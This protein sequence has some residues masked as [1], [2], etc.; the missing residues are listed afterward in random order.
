M[1]RTHFQLLPISASEADR[2]RTLGGQLY[3]SDEF[4]GYPCRQCLQDAEIGQQLLLVS[5]DPF[6]V[7]S[8]YR[9]AGPIF[10]HVNSCSPTVSINQ[11][12]PIQLT[13]RQLSVRCFDSQAM[14]ID[15][16]LIQ[17]TELEATLNGFFDSETTSYVDVHNAVRGC[18]A[19][20]VERAVPIS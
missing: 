16:A 18:W 14:M 20:R 13:C 4:P 3:V 7:D 19:V 8:P 12:F 6:R 10:L 9:S 17:G 11:M 1:N 2:L 15:A 5:F